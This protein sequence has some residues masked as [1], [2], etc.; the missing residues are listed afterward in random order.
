MNL[1]G[2]C[3]AAVAKQN[4][5]SVSALTTILEVPRMIWAVPVESMVNSASSFMA[6]EEETMTNPWAAQSAVTVGRVISA[7]S[8]T[9]V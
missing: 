4:F 2:F 9:T 1:A 5:P 6:A 8:A 7:S 3:A